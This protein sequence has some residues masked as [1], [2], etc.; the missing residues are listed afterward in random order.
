MGIQIVKISVLV[1][2]VTIEYSE[3]RNVGLR[4]EG[5]QSTPDFNMVKFR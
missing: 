5:G 3:V 4:S 1:L 2:S